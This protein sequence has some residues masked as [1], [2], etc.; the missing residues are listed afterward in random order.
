MPILSIIAAI[1]FGTGLIRWANNSDNVP[2]LPGLSQQDNSRVV[3][4]LTARNEKFSI[5][6]STGQILVPSAR[7][8]QLRMDL[9]G[10]GLS[11][12]SSLGLELLSQKQPLGTSQFIEQARYQHAL[13]TELGRTISAMRN[14]ESA[15]VHLALPKRSAF[16]RPESSASASVM[17][18]L[19]AGRS[20]ERGQIK[21]IINLVGSSVP[22]LD[23]GKVA[24][25]DEWGALLSSGSDDQLSDMSDMQFDYTRK[26]ESHYER[27]IE[28]L[29]VPLVGQGRVR[30]S[31]TADVDFSFLEQTQETFDG[32]PTQI[33]SEEQQQLRESGVGVAGIPGAMTNQPP[34]D[35]AEP[36]AGDAAAD[37]ANEG[38]VTSNMTRNYELD[39]KISHTRSS[40]GKILRLSAAVVI[41]NVLG[42][43]GTGQPVDLAPT[44]EDMEQYTALVRAAIGLDVERG[45]SVMVFN[46]PFQAAVEIEP[47]P[48]APIW[49]KPWVWSIARYV[50]IGLLIMVIAFAV[51]KPALVTLRGPELAA[52]SD[53]SGE[54]GEGEG[55]K[56]LPQGSNLVQESHG[57]IL[58][59]A[60]AIAQDDPKRVARVV[61]EWV[62]SGAEDA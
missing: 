6:S 47:P 5:D 51:V 20:L 46:K 12:N 16:V 24:I 45:D 44:P 18:R 22:Y 30:A 33:L 23:S 41:D 40:P 60:R 53:Q 36:G 50:A 8:H 9:S 34:D 29:L 26:L 19:M 3:E 11:K 14:V 1:V 42:D 4:Y 32:D 52:I 25:V 13:E 31:V 27:R 57:D 15:R 43:D 39:K 17:L 10:M 54:N 62:A 2:V 49:E 37:A 28:Q 7:A 21:A 38:L 55:D 58:L 48:A 35:A 59:M 56:A 61:R